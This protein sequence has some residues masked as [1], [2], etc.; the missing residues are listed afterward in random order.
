MKK[1]GLRMSGNE[2]E[3]ENLI[4]DY[5]SKSKDDGFKFLEIGSAAGET[6]KAVY[7]IVQENI[8]HSNWRIDGLDLVDGWSLDMDKINKFGHPIAIYKNDVRI[9]GIG[10]F[11]IPKYP[12]EQAVLWIESDPRQWLKNLKDEIIDICFIDACHCS[13][14]PQN[15]FLA[16]ESKIKKNGIIFFHDTCILS[17][18]TDFQPHGESFIDV[19]KSIDSLGLYDNK[20]PNWKFI[21]EN[22]A[23]RFSGGDGNGISIF[24][25]I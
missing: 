23:T 14:C 21:K 11:G 4:K 22:L 12:D 8:K 16:V 18:G 15:D 25:K 20:Y 24:T 19:R 5:L 6:L 17:Q 7:E 9:N 2:M 10:A 3:I 13:S 1:F